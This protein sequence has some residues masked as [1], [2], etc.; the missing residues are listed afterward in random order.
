VYNFND[1]KWCKACYN[2]VGG[3]LYGREMAA[4]VYDSSAKNTIMFAGWSVDYPGY[5]LN[6][7]WMFKYNI[8]NEPP[9]PPTK[10]VPANESLYVDIDADLSWYC[11]DPDLDDLTY[12]VYFEAGDPTPDVKLSNNQTD[13]TYDP[14]TLDY[15]E[16]YY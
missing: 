14:G 5:I 4:M 15:N 8:G 1:N 9:N 12:D 3:T 10:P 6:D 11:W 13:I 7:T 2:V 16:T